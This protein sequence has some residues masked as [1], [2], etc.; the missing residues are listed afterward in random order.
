MKLAEPI[1]AEAET[2]GDLHWPADQI[3]HWP[4]DRLVPYAKN[5]R[6]HSEAQVAQL[7]GSMREWGFT[8]PILAAENG[9][10]IAG[11]G[12]AMAAR[13]LGWADVPV[14]VARGW[15]EPQIRAY[16]IADNRLSELASWDN[17]LL[18]L[19]LADLQE[20]GFDLSL[21]GF[22]PVDLET[23]T[24]GGAGGPDTHA[25][26]MAA[27]FMVPPFSVLNGRDGWWGERKAGWLALGLRSGE[28]RDGK[29]I[30]ATS[31]QPPAVYEAKNAM[32]AKL[33]RTLGWEEFRAARP[34]LFKQSATSIFDP[35][36]CEVAYRW[37]SPPGGLVLDPFAGGSVRGVVAAKL[38]RRY[39]GIDLSEEQ[40]QANR[41]QAAAIF[42]AEPE[43]P[44]RVKVSAKMARLRFNGCDPEYIRTTCHAS[45]CES[46]VHPSG[47]RIAVLRDERD[48]LQARGA[49]IDADGYL[50]PV[51]KRCPFKTEADLCG[52]HVTPDKPFGC[53]ASPFTLNDNDT[54]IVRNR[55]TKL[56]CFK[57]GRQLPAYVAFRA[58]LDLLFGAQEAARICAHMEGGGGD[59]EAAMPAASY[60]KLREND[61]TRRGALDGQ[62][63]CPT[64]LVGDSR[65]LLQDAPGVEADFLF[66]CP[67][68]ADLERYSDDPRDLSTMPYSEFR[69]AYREVIARACARLKVDRFACFVVGEI[70]DKKGAYYDFV[71]DT[72]QAFRDAGLEFYNEAIFVT[73]VGS[74]PMRAGMMFS[75]TRKLGK[76]HQN[77]LVFLK[78][79]ARRAV[80]ACGEVEF[81][82]EV[83]ERAREEGAAE[84]PE[85][86]DDEPGD[87]Q[88]DAQ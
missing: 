58:S 38:G 9:T 22:E 2:G 15:T 45:C 70:R 33:G 8:I 18:A 87:E 23:L 27:K 37:F 71:G 31:S 62:G 49:A 11:H 80:L 77:V 30:Y 61:A 73:P 44:V 53:I 13:L 65:Q 84:D 43:A 81:D 88:L 19:E 24:N 60:A 16:A 79:D 55:Y 64:W 46:S 29:L 17:E 10:I 50:Q 69:T 83:F 12:R 6:L 14:V 78:G 54:L 26:A 25:G 72:V 63:Q 51:G 35:V 7:A 67:P 66:S 57:D 3:E 74:L 39:I 48:A 21:I 52:L 34:E 82:E 59:L 32:E 20:I 4:L 56:K 75:S 5:A 86:Q 76:S 68:Y 1:I 28:G 42:Q 40:V 47:V 41:Q 85:G 36:L